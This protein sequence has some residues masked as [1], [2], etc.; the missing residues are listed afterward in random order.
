M[1][2]GYVVLSV[3]AAEQKKSNFFYKINL[4]I[5]KIYFV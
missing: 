5:L 1:Y 4:P 3:H 2:L